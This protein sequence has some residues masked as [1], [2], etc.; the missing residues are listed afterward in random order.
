MAEDPT[1]GFSGIAPYLQHPLV[2]VG[3]V[4]LIVVGLF[5][6]FLRSDKVATASQGASGRLLLLP[7]RSLLFRRITMPRPSWPRPTRATPSGSATYR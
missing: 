2:L 5:R 3:F 4:L 6:A 1:A 7:G